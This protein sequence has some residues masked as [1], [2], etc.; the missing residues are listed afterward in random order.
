MGVQGRAVDGEDWQSMRT[1]IYGDTS[2]P[3]PPAPAPPSWSDVEGVTVVSTDGIAGMTTVR[4]SITLD[5][6]QSNVYAMAG[7]SSSAM[8]FP[9]AYQVA[10]PFGADIGG[11]P[12]AFFASVAEAEFD[13]WLTI[14]VTDGSAGV[15]SAIAA[16]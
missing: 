10:A 16:S 7:T 3:S 2:G 5:E 12:P 14:G 8:S 9:P 15:S 11:V 4:L 1:W 6:T 13:S